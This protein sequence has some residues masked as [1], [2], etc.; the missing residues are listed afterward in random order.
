MQV[1][2][3]VLAEVGSCIQPDFPHMSV[4]TGSPVQQLQSLTHNLFSLQMGIS[5]AAWD[6]DF[7]VL[8]PLKPEDILE[9]HPMVKHTDPTSSEA[10]NLLEAGKQRLGEA[11]RTSN[12][13]Q[14]RGVRSSTARASRLQWRGLRHVEGFKF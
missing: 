5:I 6:Y 4:K 14:T 7:D 9:L 12:L 3:S 8:D 1:Q 13:N 11:V 10:R 2:T